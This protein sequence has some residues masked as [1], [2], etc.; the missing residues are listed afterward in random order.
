MTVRTL[1]GNR[2]EASS[3]DH[4][5]L[6]DLSRE[7]G[8]EGTALGT[9]ETLLAALGGCTAMTLRLYARRKTWPLEG[10]RV[11]LSHAKA[12]VGVPDGRERLEVDLT[13]E[14]PLDDA[15]RQRL[16]EIARKCPVYR[17]LTS[18]LDVVERL[19]T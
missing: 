2:V 9:Y 18:A 8:G 11:A 14:G 3:G 5:M 4:R 19:A 16:L 13:L 12:P 10:V 17:T 1:E 7:E 6:L 15:Q